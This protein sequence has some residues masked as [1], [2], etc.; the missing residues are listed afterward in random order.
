MATAA[1]NKINYLNLVGY[2]I[3]VLVT[4]FASPVFNLPDNGTIS[5]QY[6]TIITPTGFTFAIWG[7]IFVSQLIFT[8]VQMLPQYRAEDIVQSGVGTMYFHACIAQSVWTFVFGYKIFWLSTVVMFMILAS[9]WSIVVQQGEIGPVSVGY[10]WLFK[11]PFEIHCGWIF[12]AFLLNV[13][14]TLIS[15]GANA[16][17]QIIVAALSLSF[18]VFIAVYVLIMLPSGGPNYTIP[19]VFVWATLGITLELISPKDLIVTTFSG[20]TILS[21]QIIS[22]CLSGLL[23]IGTVAYGIYISCCKKES[24]GAAVNESTPLM[25]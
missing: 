23:L 19:S 10:F 16:V 24:N 20:A 25:A 11:F 7:I 18:L 5:E 2:I 6:Q 3:N 9:L 15:W 4:F 1:L 21:F 13:S 14:V 17:L 12:A 22:G 8:I